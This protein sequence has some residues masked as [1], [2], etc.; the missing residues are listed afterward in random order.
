VAS[1]PQ[2]KLKAGIEL[3]DDLMRSH[4]FIYSPT[5]VGVGSG[6][7]FASGEFQHGKV[8]IRDS[9]R[10]HWTTLGIFEQTWNITARIFF[11]GLTSTSRHASNSRTL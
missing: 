10:S 9:Q 7:Q 8:S 1:A 4:G 5:A 11:Q 3:I 2:E 6:G